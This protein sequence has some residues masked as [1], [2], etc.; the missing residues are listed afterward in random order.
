MIRLVLAEPYVRLSQ[1]EANVRA[2]SAVICEQTPPSNWHRRVQLFPAPIPDLYRSCAG[3]AL[4]TLRVK[5]LE[6]S[7]LDFQTV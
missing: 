1:S 7:P 5:E 3:P 2:T 6:T 4:T